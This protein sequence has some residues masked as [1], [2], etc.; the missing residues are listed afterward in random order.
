[1][2]FND[3]ADMADVDVAHQQVANGR[4]NVGFQRIRP[5]ECVLGVAPARRLRL[6]VGLGTT[7]KCL[8]QRLLVNLLLDD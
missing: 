1:M 5:L 7:P 4:V 3:G 6:D 8:I 2:R